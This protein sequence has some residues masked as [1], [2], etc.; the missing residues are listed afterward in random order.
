MR[1]TY[2][3]SHI[4]VANLLANRVEAGA[5]L[6]IPE[7]PHTPPAA[8][9][10]PHVYFWDSLAAVIIN[11]EN[12]SRESISYG[13]T[14]FKEV[15]KGQQPN[16][17]IGNM[18]FALKGR[19]LDFERW[20][21]FGIN[22]KTSNYGQAPMLAMAAASIYE[23]IKRDEGLGEAKEFLKE[24]YEPTA[25][26][27][28]YHEKYRSNST[29]DK[30]IGIIHPHETGRD[31]DPT[32]DFIKPLRLKRN[33]PDTP[34]II[35]KINVPIDYFSIIWHGWKLKGTRGE[36]AKQRELFWV[37]DVMM[38]CIYV[39]NLRE[40]GG[41]AWELGEFDDAAEFSHLALQVEEQI[42]TDMWFPDARGGKGA[43]YALD[44]NGDPIEEVSISNLFALVL[45]NLDAKQVESLLGM[46]DESF[47]VNFPL[48][49]VATD[50]PNY[51]P[52]NKETD[53]LWRGPTWIIT[54]WYLVMRGLNMQL[55]NTKLQERPD[56]LDRS[57]HW[58][59]RVVESSLTMVKRTLA[60]HF[61]PDTG[62][63]QRPRVQK[64]AW[65]NLAYVMVAK[66]LKSTRH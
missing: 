56:L 7:T 6:G 36:V 9:H 64:F 21:A 19:K 59:V 50:S 10:Y 2:P 16:G 42:K 14:E 24:V 5:K 40:M 54:N 25:R 66:I 41:L 1:Q 35:D 61:N 51:D 18:Q 57:Q 15:L 39:D 65:D 49:S 29:D 43:F 44:S 28:R 34:N 53:R 32:F 13:K 8:G 30:L 17:F 37:N 62:E 48:P 63:G 22:A 23:A 3:E 45:P 20:L 4:A 31:S 11:A 52:H 58:A 47:D 46:M 55:Q 27:Y 60:E 38:N 26:Y 12:G 33:G